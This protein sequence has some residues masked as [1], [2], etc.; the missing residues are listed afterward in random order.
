MLKE[1]SSF[2]AAITHVIGTETNHVYSI[3]DIASMGQSVNDAL[4][5]AIELIP[6]NQL[7]SAIGS[8]IAAY[9]MAD[10]RV[11]AYAIGSEMHYGYVIAHYED[12]GDIVR[13]LGIKEHG[14]ID[15]N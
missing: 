12:N 7:S 8:T 6:S 4:E 15:S 1:F 2:H 13:F 14:P 11:S 10:S 5:E 3:T 9:C